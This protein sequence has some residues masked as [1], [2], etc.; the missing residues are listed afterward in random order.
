MRENLSKITAALQNKDKPF[1]S[2]K[3]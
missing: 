2:K 3:R 1:F